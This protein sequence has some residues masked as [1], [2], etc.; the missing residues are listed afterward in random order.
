[1]SILRR[2]PTQTPEE[3][4]VQTQVL[5]EVEAARAQAAREREL[6]DAEH[7][8]RQQEINAAGKAAA[9]ARRS[10]RRA[11]VLAKVRVLAPLVI[12]NGAAVYGQLDYAYREVAPR[13][14]NTAS[15]IALALMFA[16]AVESIA[17]YIQWHAHDAL[18]QKSH[19]T[20]AR[21]RRNSYLV[22]SVVASINYTHFADGSIFRPTAA[23]VAFGLLSSMSPWLWG[24]HTRRA[25]HVQLLASDEHLID[26]GGAEF[27]TARRRAF[28]IRTWH[29]RRWSI[30]HSE[31]DPR[32]A[33]REYNAERAARREARASSKAWR[34]ARRAEQ[35]LVKASKGAAAKSK[36]EDPVVEPLVDE[37]VRDPWDYAL[38]IGPEPAP[39]PAV[40]DNLS[41]SRPT[42]R[43]APPSSRDR[44]VAAHNR[45][46]SASHEE[47]AARLKV[48]VKTVERHRPPKVSDNLSDTEQP[49]ALI[50]GH[51]PE[52]VG[53][54]HNEKEN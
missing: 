54:V 5:I 33:W 42:V 38:P 24:L 8:R 25:Q 49:N 9:A 21:L 28:P 51:V 39:V 2:R 7:R 31:Q 13:D 17:L 43:K 27:S 48:S 35:R 53:A 37:P 32:V 19:A 4:R 52:L 36:P 16:L 15:K 6:A 45:T 11:V 26:D 12:V 30:D 23:A 3:I 44:V 18:M 29:A 10:A 20:A 1:V 41:V 34:D 14:W 40:S 47:L 22:A 46:P 50:N